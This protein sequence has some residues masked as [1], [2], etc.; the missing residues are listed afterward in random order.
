MIVPI[1]FGL[2][3]LAN[4]IML[5][6]TIAKIGVNELG[7]SNST[8][9]L[10][11]WIPVRL[12]SHDVTVVP[13]LAPII[14]PTAW[15][16][17]MI[18]ELTNPTTITVVADDDWITAV[19][20]APKSTALIGELVNFSKICSSLPPE[21]LASPS[22]ITCIPYKNRASPPIIVNT[23]NISMLILISTHTSY[24]VLVRYFYIH[25]T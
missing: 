7:L 1:S 23:P 16:S 14:M 10:S 12:S 19:T 15:L 6:P 8:N 24:L 21:V 20:P 3:D 13:I 5:T 4:K 25:F 18:P 2:L 9:K 11:P 22:P 17:F